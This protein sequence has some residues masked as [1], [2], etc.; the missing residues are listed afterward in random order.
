MKK[1]LLALFCLLISNSCFANTEYSII[2]NKRVFIQQV[3]DGGALGYIC[4]E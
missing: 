4:P 3:L 1:T 2:S